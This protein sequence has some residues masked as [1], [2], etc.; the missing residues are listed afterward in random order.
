MSVIKRMHLSTGERWSVLFED[1]GKWLAGSYVLKNERLKDAVLLEKRNAPELLY[2]IDGKVITMV[3]KRG[4][5]KKA[6]LRKKRVII[7]D[8]WRN[9]YRPGEAKGSV[10]VIKGEGIKT[11]YKTLK[12]FIKE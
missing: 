8:T 9:T 2:L 1:E 6:P 12:S 7:I 4:R 5:I 10:L 11:E 3:S